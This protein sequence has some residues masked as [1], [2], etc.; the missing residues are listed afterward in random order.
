MQRPSHMLAHPLH[1]ISMHCIVQSVRHEAK[2]SGVLSSIGNIFK[3]DG[4][5]GYIVSLIPHLLGDVV[6]LWGCNLVAHFIND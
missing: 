2:Y 6:F 1:V 4:L 5:L 3:K